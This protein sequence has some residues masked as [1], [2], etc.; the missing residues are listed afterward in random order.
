[1]SGEDFRVSCSD[2]VK[3]KD[4]S[5]QSADDER[6]V[7]IAHPWVCVCARV[8]VFGDPSAHTLCTVKP[9]LRNPT[10][11]VSNYQRETVQPHKNLS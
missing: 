10:N 11:Y 9:A 4:K 6:S 2:L 5:A 7:H 8:C 1:M 3:I